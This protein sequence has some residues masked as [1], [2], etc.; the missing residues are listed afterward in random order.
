MKYTRLFILLFAALAV[1]CSKDLDVPS[2]GDIVVDRVG[3]KFSVGE[4]KQV[5]FSPANLQYNAVSRQWRFADNQYDCIADGNANISSYYDGWIDL[6]GWGTSGFMVAPYCS[7][8]ESDD[9]ENGGQGFE[10]NNNDWGR[11][12]TISNAGSGARVWRTLS[13]SEWEYLLETRPNAK[14]K[15]APAFVCDYPGLVILSDNFRMPDS[16]IF[17]VTFD[18]GYESNIYNEHQWSKMEAA[19]AI[20]LPAAGYRMGNYVDEVDMTGYYWTSSYFE[21]GNAYAFSFDDYEEDLSVPPMPLHYGA[22]VRLV[23]DAK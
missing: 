10:N 2:D 13:A 4:G 20:F 14:E 22:A 8:T 23:R 5:F 7:S 16:C 15:F 6:F 21:D 17:A 11:F 18:N 12:I 19:G 9:Y 3:G 1:S